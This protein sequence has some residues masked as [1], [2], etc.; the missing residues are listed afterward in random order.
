MVWGGTTHSVFPWLFFSTCHSFH[1]QRQDRT[2]WPS[3]APCRTDWIPHCQKWPNK[4]DQCYALK[5]PPNEGQ[6]FPLWLSYQVVQ[7][8]RSGSEEQNSWGWGAHIHMTRCL[9]GLTSEELNLVLPAMFP[10]ASEALQVPG[11]HPSAPYSQKGTLH[12]CSGVAS[13]TKCTKWG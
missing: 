9:E 6:R 7:H 12:R 11:A 10:V 8:S 13:C 5:K 3:W 2:G 4:P 1:W